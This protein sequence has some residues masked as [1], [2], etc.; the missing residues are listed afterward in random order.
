MPA[1]AAGAP[2]HV[3]E[4]MAETFADDS[5]ALAIDLG[6]AGK[7]LLGPGEEITIPPGTPHGFRNPL[8]IETVFVTTA[9][10]GAE[11][12]RFLRTMY[13]LA[14]NGRTDASGAPRNPVDLAA[15]L[16]PMDM[17]IA[18]LPRTLQRVLVRA[19]LLARKIFDPNPSAASAR[20]LEKEA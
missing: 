3:H 1:Q 11:L 12:E 15:A 16:A 10:P 18:P 2:L 8:S 5:G 6:K 13:D 20:V 14:N 19:L 7:R 17:T 9:T 4:T